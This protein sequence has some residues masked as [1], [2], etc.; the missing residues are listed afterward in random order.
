MQGFEKEMERARAAVGEEL[1]ALIYHPAPAVILALLDNPALDESHLSL[2]LARKDLP[3]EVLEEIGARKAL[4]KNY[5]VKKALLFHPRTPRLVGLRL[6]KDLYLMDL[7]Q[8]SLS[9][10]APAELK[11]Y[12]EE[13]VVARMPQLPLGQKIALAR[14]GPARVAGA[15]LAE[16]HAQVMPVA[17]ENPYLTEAQVL[18]A[19]AREK[20]PTT[21]VQALAKHRKWS[22][23]YNVRLAIVRNPSAPIS[24]VLGFLPQLT[25]SDLRELAAPGIVPENLR[26]YLEAEVRRRMLA[27]RKHAAR[28]AGVTEAA[29]A[30]QPEDEKRA[31]EEKRRG[32]REGGSHR[33]R[34]PEKSDDEA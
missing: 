23:A 12:A 15:L 19:L 17:L 2:L 8:F 31:K 6:L 33:D 25:V 24:I 11:R 9:V 4:L 26:K 28:E 16:G 18:R 20:V 10:S 3:S 7:V 1:K 22:Q 32:E 27:S 14:R 34:R 29:L 30:A 5:A 21:V 13:Q